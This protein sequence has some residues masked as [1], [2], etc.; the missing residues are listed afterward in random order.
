LSAATQ[1]KNG[2]E[3][4]GGGGGKGRIVRIKPMRDVMVKEAAYHCHTRGIETYNF[5]GWDTFEGSA[6]VGSGARKVVVGEARGKGGV[7]SLEKL[8][9]GEKATVFN[10]IQIR[11][12]EVGVEGLQ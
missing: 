12:F 9:E 10:S 3:N 1:T 7:R 8:T 2:D 4:A 5:R 6:Q 11:G